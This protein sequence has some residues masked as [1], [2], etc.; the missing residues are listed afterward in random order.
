MAALAPV[1]LATREAKLSVVEWD[2]ATA[3]LRT[4]SLHSWETR[5]LPGASPDAAAALAAA[6]EA[7]AAA[8]APPR[9]LADPEGRAAAVLLGRGGEVA[10]LRTVDFGVGAEDDDGTGPLGAAAV[11]ASYVFDM[12]PLGEC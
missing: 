7:P 6:A 4:S 10:L 12:R 5:A 8:H 2:P 3:A 1:Q 9:V 11:A